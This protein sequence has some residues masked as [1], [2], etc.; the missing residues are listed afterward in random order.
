MPKGTRCWPSSPAA[1]IRRSGWH[2]PGPAGRKP[3]P[4]NIDKFS[5]LLFAFGVRLQQ[6]LDVPVGLM[7]GAV[8]GTPSGPWL[9]EEAY[10]SDAACKEVIKKFAATYPLA[11]LQKKYEE[12]LAKWEKDAEEAKKAN[13]TPPPRPAPP[14][15]PGEPAS[16]IGNLYEAHIRPFIPFGIRGVLWDQGESGTAIT[17]V[18]QYTLMGALIRGWRKDWGQGEFPFLYIQKPSGGGCAWDP[19]DPVTNK[20]DKFAPLPA[21][22]P[23]RR[24]LSREPHPDHAL[25]ADRHGDRQRPGPRHPPREQVRATAPAPPGWPWAWSTDGS[26][27]TTARFSRDTRSKETRCGSTSRTSARAWRS[28]TATSCKASR[29]AGEDKKFFWADAV[30]EGDTIVLSCDKVSKPVAVRYAW[31]AVHPWA[32]LFNK[33]GLPALPFRTDSW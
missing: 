2:G 23:G 31:A 28:S 25:S 33:D 11:D 13:K 6:E 19:K 15:K 32:N 21:Q 30:I 7:L 20:A 4:A 3:T 9:S 12:A 29:V 14:R 27:N 26:S 17:G 8:G 24:R 18:D 10:V 5:A 16:K 1:P 22:V